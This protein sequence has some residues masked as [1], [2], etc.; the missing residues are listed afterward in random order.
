MRARLQ[1]VVDVLRGD[2]GDHPSLRRAALARAA[3][4]AGGALAA[5]EA[6]PDALAGWVDKVAQRAWT[7]AD[8]DVAALRAAGFDEDAIFEV[9]IAAATGA[10]IARYEAAARAI[11]AAAAPAT[12]AGQG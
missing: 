10:A 4:L 12:K 7:I 1:K 5:A 3:S 9:T 6:L 8:D 2:G 11:A